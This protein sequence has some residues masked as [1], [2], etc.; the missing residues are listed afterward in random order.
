MSAPPGSP[1]PTFGPTAR[2]IRQTVFGL[3][4]LPLST[5]A[6]RAQ[7]LV[8]GAYAPAPVGFNVV[9]VSANVS[10]GD[11]AFDPSLP[12]EDARAPLGVTFLGFARALCIAGRSADSS[13]GWRGT[14]T[15]GLAAS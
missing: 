5:A 8:P 7:D 14:A 11:V 1:T 10:G 3:L 15:S 4:A 2:L 12:V 13:V 6:V 9:T